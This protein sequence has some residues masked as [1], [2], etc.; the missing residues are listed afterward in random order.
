MRMRSQAEPETRLP[1]IHARSNRDT[2]PA[3][4]TASVATSHGTRAWKLDLLSELAEQLAE[5]ALDLDRN[6]SAECVQSLS[7]Q[8][9]ETKALVRPSAAARMATRMRQSINC[10]R[11]GD[12]TSLSL[13]AIEL[14]RLAIREIPLGARRTPIHISLLGYVALKLTALSR[15]VVTNWTAVESAVGEAVIHAYHLGDDLD[16]LRIDQTLLHTLAA[17][18]RALRTKERQEIEHA[19]RRLHIIAL[20]LRAQHTQFSVAN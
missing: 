17:L 19:A 7:A 11:C 14:Y 5:Y 13:A 2:P 15:Q 20:R 9:V 4:R 12:L 16:G 1:A 18:S 3:P 6:H 10:N 8:V